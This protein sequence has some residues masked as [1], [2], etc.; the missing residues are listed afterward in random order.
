MHSYTFIC[1]LLAV[2]ATAVV[3]TPVE[4]ST[5]SATAATA[6]ATASLF[7]GTRLTANEASAA[8]ANATSVVPLTLAAL[9]KRDTSAEPVTKRSYVATCRRC[10]VYSEYWLQCECRE[11]AQGSQRYYCSNLNLNNCIENKDGVLQWK[12]S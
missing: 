11:G 10:S 1:T 7:Y 8:L 6:P 2:A 5:P 12:A 3:A 9:D 4:S